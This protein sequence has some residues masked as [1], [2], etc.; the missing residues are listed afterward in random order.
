MSELASST[1]S[2]SNGGGHAAEGT[3]NQY[4]PPTVSKTEAGITQW[5]TNNPQGSGQQKFAQMMFDTAQREKDLASSK[6]NAVKLSRVADYKDLAQKDPQRFNI[7]LQSHGIDPKDYAE[8]A[9]NNYQVPQRIANPNG[10]GQDPKIASWANQHQ[11][12]YSQAEAILKARGY[13]G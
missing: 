3:I 7:A 2:L 4:L 12:P 1:A 11:L 10:V 9:S 5:L 6:V 8:F 13:G